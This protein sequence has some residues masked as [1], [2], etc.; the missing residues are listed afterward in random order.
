MLRVLVLLLVL[1]YW[2]YFPIAAG[3]GYLAEE[4]YKSE[5]QEQHERVQALEQGQPDLINLS[6]FRKDAH[7]G[8]VDEV[9]I[10]G[11]I[12]T[13]YNYN[14]TKSTNG[15]QTSE[16][17][18]YLLFGQGDTAASKVVRA[19]LVLTEAEK[20]KFMSDFG[21]FSS[22]FSESGEHLLFKFN[23]F[24]S[25]SDSFASLAKDALKE[26]QLRASADFIYIK[27]FFN[28]RKAALAPHGAPEKTRMN[29]WLF[30]AVVAFFGIIK[31]FFGRRTKT[32][33]VKSQT[34]AAPTYAAARPKV[35]P[36]GSIAADSPLG[37]LQD[38]AIDCGVN[39]AAAA[40]DMAQLISPS[41]TAPAKKAEKK[42]PVKLAL[43]AIIVVATALSPRT[44]GFLLPFLMV[45]GFWALTYFGARKT[46]KLVSD[47]FQ[48][49]TTLTKAKPPVRNTAA[50]AN[51]PLPADLQQVSLNRQTMPKPTLAKPKPVV[52]D[53][54]S[55]GPIRSGS[56]SLFGRLR[57]KKR[58]DPF[59]KLAQARE[60]F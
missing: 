56:D 52:R 42:F 59:E 14:L 29:V 2:V 38:K 16:R 47:L 51:P 55:D 53:S 49:T 12:N 58:P 9:N 48:K 13:D 24:A 36:A 21:A 22:G 40:P 39:S 7:I 19:A 5:L 17:F 35:S 3:V 28:G 43:L 6:Q 11:W 44:V 30:A 32:P 60:S 37:R 41:V 34:A 18:M 20:E 8:P 50:S 25:G 10:E 45:F 33:S 23:G 26:K 15:V 46:S 31:F 54:F 4:M 27:P 57:R 1:P